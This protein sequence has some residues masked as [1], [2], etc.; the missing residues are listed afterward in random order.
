[1]FYEFRFP[2]SISIKSTTSIEFNTNIMVSKN[3]QEQRIANRENSRLIYNVANGI[4]TKRDLDRI[5]NLF[6][7]VK[8]RNIGFRFK[9]WTDYSARKQILGLGT[10]D[11]KI[12]QFVKNYNITVNDEN[13]IYVRKITKPVKDTVKIF[14]NDIDVTN[15][16]DINYK[17][18]EINFKIAP[19]ENEIIS[20]DF[21]FDVPVRFDTDV[22]ELSLNGQ[23]SGRIKDIRLVEIL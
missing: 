16:V 9:D 21:E 11:N 2:D 4:K 6:R 1:M 22:I 8:G 14:V 15:S 13:V 3:G 17:N 7:I 20:A 19:N 10:G 5:I 23:N 12:Y 18:G